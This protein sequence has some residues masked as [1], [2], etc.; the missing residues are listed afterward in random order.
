MTPFQ[1]ELI[2]MAAT[3]AVTRLRSGEVSPMEMLD[4]ALARHGEVDGQINAMP[5]ICADRAAAKTREIA[6]MTVPNDGKPWLAGLPIAIKDLA[7]V[8]G[9]RT[10]KGSLIHKDRIAERSDILV[11][12][13]E[14]RG[15]VVIGKSNTP[16]FG[17]GAHTFNE[18]FG[19]TRN[20]WDLTKSA[21]G[22]SG[23]SAAALASRQVW[24][25]TGSDFGGSL[26]NPASFCSVVGFRAS[27]GRVARGPRTHSFGMMSIEGP[28]AR[29]VADAA[30]M[31]DCQTG[32]HP[33]DPISLPAPE[34]PFSATL[35]T[36]SAPA[37]IGYAAD[38][39]GIVPVAQ[40]VRGVL[41]GAMGL[42]SAAGFD[43]EDASPDLNDASEIFAVLRAEQ[44]VTNFGHLLDSHADLLKPDIIWNIEQGRKLNA[45]NIGRAERARSKLFQRVADWF[46]DFDLLL[47]PA[48]IVTPFDADERYVREVDGHV[49]D[50]YSQWM[51]ICYAITITG[52]PAISIP[53]GFTK[54]GLPV[55]LQ[56]VGRPRGER[57]LL[58]AAHRFEQ[59][60]DLSSKHSPDP[61]AGS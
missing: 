36:A 17:A 2:S 34:V 57:A 28:M 22:S 49:F 61:D 19:V 60:F 46:D 53:C 24:L 48:T 47:C 5:I 6:A 16:E 51:A 10:T 56:I 37:R 54:E 9:V 1:K 42:L 29:T 18:V 4:A 3:D 33:R 23:G 45:E 31:F 13:L 38:L 14:A 43:V 44:F 30:M 40:D 55:G 12:A 59:I 21:G 25:A 26:R 11:E 8:A 32:T 15:A 20:P 52:C 41:S 58:A 27:A 35:E 50:N 39:G 7:D